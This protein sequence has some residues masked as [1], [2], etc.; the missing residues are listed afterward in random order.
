MS[1]AAAL[2]GSS[3]EERRGSKKAPERVYVVNVVVDED[4]DPTEIPVTQHTT[5]SQVI[6]I[7]LNENK[8]LQ[9]TRHWA[10]V[11]VF[12][13]SVRVRCMYQPSPSARVLSTIAEEEQ[14]F[15]GELVLLMTSFIAASSIFFYPVQDK[16]S[17]H[18]SQRI[19]SDFVLEANKM[20]STG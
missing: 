19:R 8:H 5:F 14:S 4:D 6:D 7:L 16:K 15:P 13:S 18:V 11:F 9:D 10:I 2:F 17:A 20:S 12:N 1:G 3:K